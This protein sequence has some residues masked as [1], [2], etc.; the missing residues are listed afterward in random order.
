MRQY[1]IVKHDLDSF[2]KLPGFIWRVG[3]PKSKIPRGFRGVR[4]GDRWIEFAYIKNEVDYKPC[5]LVKGFYECTKTHWYDSI[6]LKEGQA[7]GYKHAHM[8]RG[9]KCS[10]YQPRH[11]V[12]VPPM[13]ELLPKGIQPRT[14][15]AR[16]ERKDFDLIRK[17]TESR[18]LNPSKIPFLKREP[19]SCVNFRHAPAFP[20]SPL[21]S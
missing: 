11:P 4:K 13:S 16:I 3:M 8:I 9:R 14:T 18:Y 17:E 5:S 7:Y 10:G 19:L 1:F 21:E 12:T 6:P 20:A 15:I 2:E